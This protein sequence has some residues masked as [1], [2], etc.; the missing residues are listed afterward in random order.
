M[1]DILSR[2]LFVNVKYMGNVDWYRTTSNPKR[3]IK[4]DV[5]VMDLFVFLCT[6]T[7]L[8]KNFYKSKTTLKAVLGTKWL[9][10]SDE[11]W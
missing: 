7:I 9:P 1:A 3:N 2:R 8:H 4:G 5:T 6:I 10:L 11:L